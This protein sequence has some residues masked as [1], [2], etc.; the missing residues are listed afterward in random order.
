MRRKSNE[1]SSTAISSAAHF[2]RTRS[3]FL[4]FS[5]SGYTVFAGKGLKPEDVE[6]CFELPIPFLSLRPLASKASCSR[7]SEN[8]RYF[9]PRSE[10][11]LSPCMPRPLETPHCLLMGVTFRSLPLRFSTKKSTSGTILLRRGSGL[12]SA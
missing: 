10:G 11:E 6:R 8:G 7:A 1:F 5:H 12:F 3:P 2:S 4:V 9:V